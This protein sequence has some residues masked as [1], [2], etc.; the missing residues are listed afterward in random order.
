MSRCVSLFPV[1]L[2]AAA[3]APVGQLPPARPPATATVPVVGLGESGNA[4]TRN[5]ALRR[6]HSI[7]NEVPDRIRYTGNVVYRTVD[8][9]ELQLDVYLRSGPVPGPNRQSPDPQPR[10]DPSRDPQSPDRQSRDRE[11]ADL[12]P[13][14]ADRPHD[15]YPALIFVHGGGWR[16]GDKRLNRAILYDFVDHGYATFSINYS[17]APKC[18]F[19]ACIEDCKAAVRWVRANAGTYGVDPKRIGLVGA[20]AGGHL[21]ALAAVSDA[22]DFLDGDNPD[23]S[24]RVSAVVAYFGVFDFRGVGGAAGGIIDMFMGGLE[25]DRRELFRRASPI[26]Y[27]E[28]AR[29]QQ[30]IAPPFPPFMLIHGDEDSLVSIDQSRRMHCALR[31]VGADSTLIEVKGGQ[32]GLMTGDMDPPPTEFRRRM[33]EFLDRHVKGERRNPKHEIRNN[34]RNQKKE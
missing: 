12:P 28:A 9:A 3:A 32:H 14:S 11:G 1:V 2:V 13:D 4:G 7:V 18:R 34:D 22:D 10:D 5:E 21:V 30:F 6:F 33:F 16:S 8:G 24:S 23:Q 31:D 26:T 20:S 15:L 17:L 25:N 19:P 27:V 29:G